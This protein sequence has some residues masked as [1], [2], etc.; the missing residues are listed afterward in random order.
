MKKAVRDL[1]LGMKELPEK[2]GYWGLL[3]NT[4]TSSVGL[5]PASAKAFQSVNDRYILFT[6]NLQASNRGFGLVFG[7]VIGFAILSMLG[8]ALILDSLYNDSGFVVEQL[9]ALIII[10]F[11]GSGF[12]GWAY[13][14][15]RSKVSPPVVL[16]KKFRRFYYWMNRKDGWISLPYDDVQPVSM[17]ARMY[18]T[19]GGSTAYVLAIVDLVPGSRRI[20]WYLPLSQPQ[21]SIETPERIWEFIRCY[22]D[23]TPEELPPV[24]ALPAIDDPKADL[25]R[26]DRFLF[27]GLVDENHRV[28]PGIFSKLYVGFVGGTMYWFERAGLWISRTAPRP[29]WPE[30]IAEEMALPVD[31]SAYKIR[32]PTPAQRLANENAL[33]HMRRR[34]MVLGGI[35]TIFVLTMFAVL[36]VPPWL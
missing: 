21:R 32:A 5:E 6:P 25:A 30:E 26:M 14:S 33:P 3:L 29:Q 8:S 35:S 17:I 10:A 20:R 22:M 34:W 27:G 16:S 15:L 31:S 24:E 2:G 12:F 23:R 9:F 36:G 4:K 19:A 11:L 28:V 18:S 7:S 1:V 13:I